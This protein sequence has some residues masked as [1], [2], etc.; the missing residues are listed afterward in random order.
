MNEREVRDYRFWQEQVEHANAVLRTVPQG[1][2]FAEQL[3][4][5]ADFYAEL[6]A[7]R[8]QKL[9]LELEKWDYPIEEPTR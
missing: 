3:R 1:S 7:A 6:V 2:T 9:R 4:G 8:V 5:H